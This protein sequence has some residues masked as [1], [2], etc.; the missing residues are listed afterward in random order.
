MTET[1]KVSIA[2]KEY[3]FRILSALEHG[4]ILDQ[5]ETQSI[6]NRK[7]VAESTGLTMKDVE[8]LDSPTFSRLLLEFH[9]TH[10][11]KGID[12]V[13]KDLQKSTT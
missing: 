6:A 5:S 11:P 12:A 8:G 13:I 7:L 2:G 10:A 9:R 4:N 1:V 3:V